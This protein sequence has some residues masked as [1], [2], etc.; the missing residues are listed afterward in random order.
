MRSTNRSPLPPDDLV[1]I[2]KPV[3]R[4]IG[5]RNV[6]GTVSLS[7]EE[8]VHNLTKRIAGSHNHRMGR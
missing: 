8:G 7:D 5:A 3:L 6:S 2:G 4:K 1:Q